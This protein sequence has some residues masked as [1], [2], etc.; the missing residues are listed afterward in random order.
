[1][2]QGFFPRLCVLH[3]SRSFVGQIY[4]PA[5]NYTL[6]A[7]CV[8]VVVFL[9]SSS[10]IGEAYGVTVLAVML[11]TTLMMALLLLC[12]WRAPLVVVAAFF[13]VFAGIEGALWSA[14]LVKV[15]EWVGGWGGV[16]LCSGERERGT[17]TP[18]TTPPTT[19]PR[20]PAMAGSP[21]SS[22]PCGSRSRPSVWSARAPTRPRCAPP[23][24]THSSSPPPT[25]ATPP[26][27]PPPRRQPR[28]RRA[29]PPLARS[30]RPAASIPR[31]R[32]VALFYTDAPDG[33]APPV[34]AHLLPRLPVLYELNILLH[35]RYVPLP[36]V[37]PSERL[38]A[39]DSSVAGFFDV[40]ARYGYMERPIH[41]A[42]FAAAVVDHVLDRLAVRLAGSAAADATL[43]AAL[44]VAPSRADAG[45]VRAGVT[46]SSPPL[47]QDHAA[48][49]D[50]VTQMRVLQHAR[51]QHSV[52]Y[53]VGMSDVRLDDD[54]SPARGGVRARAR[55]AC[56]W[57]CP[58]PGCSSFFRTT[59]CR[60]TACRASR[61]CRWCCRLILMKLREK[62]EE[63]EPAERVRGVAALAAP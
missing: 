36:D 12:V 49:A 57:A 16:C 7:M 30:V 2:A 10:S 55:A 3:T 56:C 11:V 21:S 17:A 46:A 50:I 24:S 4:V 15:G 52:V 48:A 62:V 9:K 43:A 44:V 35:V 26:P 41:D 59:L 27:P 23:R 19:T 63:T 32:G 51:D 58:L 47:A 29:P 39:R 60:R 34:L 18:P 42:A 20:S 1:M 13:V 61:R 8:L 22:L 14:T 6:A 5:I 28:Y 31:V 54:D 37:A 38:L 53:V 33:S 25:P 45:A 40:V